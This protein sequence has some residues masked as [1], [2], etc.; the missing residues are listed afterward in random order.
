MSSMYV[1]H[2]SSYLLS[3]SDSL[4]SFWVKPIVNI[5]SEEASNKRMWNTNCYQQPITKTIKY[6]LEFWMV[7]RDTAT[8][9]YHLKLHVNFLFDQLRTL[10]SALK[11]LTRHV[12]C[13][14][15]Q[16]LRILSSSLMS[17]SGSRYGC[18]SSPS[19]PMFIHLSFMIPCTRVIHTR[20]WKGTTLRLSWCKCRGSSDRNFWLKYRLARTPQLINHSAFWS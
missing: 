19:K 9:Y 1:A 3:V 6:Q 8:N 2:T 11:G 17:A 10:D 7:K 4:I 20:L 13:D 18:K 5:F 12:R 15:V 16:S 14:T